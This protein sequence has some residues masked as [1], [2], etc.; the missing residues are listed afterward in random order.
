MM[1]EKKSTDL[2]SGDLSLIDIS[3]ALPFIHVDI[4]GFIASII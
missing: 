4:M 2:K 1:S 3:A